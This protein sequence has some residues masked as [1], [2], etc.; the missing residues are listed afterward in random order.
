MPEIVLQLALQ[1][2]RSVPGQIIREVAWLYPVLESL[3]ILGIALLFGTTA[4]VDLRLL[5]VLRDRI[6]V[7]SVTAGLLPIAHVGFGLAV[8]SGMLMFTGIA[9]SIVRSDAA[10]WKLAL[11]TVALGNVLVFHRGVFRRVEDWD[12]GPTPATVRLAAITSLVSWSG[13]VF[14]GRFLAYV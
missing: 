7:R 14:A 10:T 4:A 5:G 2:E 6:P 13:C 12:I 9:A 3:H 11:L 1:I 8:I